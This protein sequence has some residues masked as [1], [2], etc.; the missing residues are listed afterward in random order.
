[1]VV[2]AGTSFEERV[3]RILLDAE[4]I[5]AE[6]LEQ[7]REASEEHAAGLLDTLVSM[8][9]V[10]RETLMTVLSFQLR[11]PVVDLKTVQ[12]DPEAVQLVPED[13]ARE[14]SILPIGFEADGSLRIATMEPNDFQVLAQLSSTTGRQSKFA[15]ALSGGLDELIE[16]TYATGPAQRAPEAPAAEPG[17]G[18]VPAVAAPAPSSLLGQDMSQLPAVQAVEMVT[19]QAVK[20]RASDVHLVP[21]SDS[22]NVLFRLDGALQE[23]VTLPLRLH[24]SMIAR[25]KVLAE[26]DISESRRPQDGSFSLEFGEKTVDFRVS[27]IGITWGEMMVIRVLDRSGGLLS[28]EDLGLALTP[29]SAWRQLLTLPFGLLLVS[30]PTGSGKTTT[31]YASVMELVQDR[32]N[33]MTVEDPVEYRMENLHQI[34]VNRAAGIDFPT[35]LKSI[36]RLDPDVILVGEVR[37]VETATTAIDAALTGH[38]VLA[39]IHGNDAAS[40]MVRLLDMGI[41]PFMAATA[42]A[43]MLAQ[44]LVRKVCPHCRAPTEPGAAE[45]MAY[46]SEMQEP[47]GSGHRAACRVHRHAGHRLGCADGQ[48]RDPEAFQRPSGAR[49]VDYGVG[50]GGR[51]RQERL[52]WCSPGPPAV[53]GRVCGS[54]SWY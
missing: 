5:T 38:L 34:E 40:S 45:A 37:D 1:M 12:V 49:P 27:A 42:G 19:L 3:G 51:L 30:G 17:V 39:S 15:L 54:I 9:T 35:G 6:Q 48:C 14:H 26:M 32:G 31:L 4:F 7:A 10:A 20:R 50:A 43:G 18:G 44:R 46:E 25:I 28:L 52:A 33:I 13:F 24:E 36:M 2:R 11:I 29:L 23:V 8:G 16:R 41:E 22:S 53:Q 21:T 47:A